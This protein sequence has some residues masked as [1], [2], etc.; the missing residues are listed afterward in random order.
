MVKYVDTLVTFAEFPNE[1]SLC[2]NIS[3]CPNSCPGCHSPYLAQDIGKVLNKESLFRLIEENKGIS[4][5][6][7]MGGDQAPNTISW[8][9]KCVKEQY[10]ELKVGW[11]SGRDKLSPEIDLSYFDF[12]KLGPYNEEKGPL[13][14]PNTNQ[15]FYSKGEHLHKISAYKDSFYDVTNWFWKNDTNNETSGIS[16]ES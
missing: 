7:L 14:N 8:L 4:C 11:Y 1:I 6:G 10:P 9:A 3:G 5:V 2:I 13:T 15:H 12:Y 16:T